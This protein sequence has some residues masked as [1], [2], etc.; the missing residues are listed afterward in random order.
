MKGVLRMKT[1]IAFLVTTMLLTTTALANTATVDGITWTY[2]VSDGKVSIGGPSK[3]IPVSTTG[4]ISIPS[5]LGGMPVVNISDSA[6]YRCSGLTS[7]SICSGITNIGNYA[8]QNC[9]S[10]ES[11]TIPDG[12]SRI[13]WDA[14]M[15]CSALTNVSIPD[16]VVNI[17]SRAFNDCNIALFDN[18]SISGVALV[19]GW[20]VS[21]NNNVS[22]GLDLTGCRGIAAR[23]FQDCQSLTKVEIPD[24]INGISGLA[25]AGCANL[26]SITIG[27]GVKYIG[28][29][30]FHECS[31]L[32]NIVV[33]KSVTNMGLGVFSSCY[34]LYN[35]TFEGEMPS[36]G[37]D[38]FD[39][40]P[41]ECVAFVP[42]WANG[43]EIDSNG[44]WQG[45]LVEY[46]G[47]G[48]DNK[49]VVS[50][51]AMAIS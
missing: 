4:S 38:V 10:L 49:G 45:L 43:Y 44:K 39:N 31:A 42:K 51:M 15:G 34:N 30:A 12:V 20:I 7:V 28:D 27:D 9:T 21:S 3:A 37:E 25:F 46:Y 41:L 29:N 22:T 19:D 32:N 24:T 5:T 13:G 23:S 33:P 11:I 2:T 16:S 40:V 8:F 6:F 17:G 35:V 47:F 1:Q 26:E 18:E 14:F 36:L 48:V 50:K